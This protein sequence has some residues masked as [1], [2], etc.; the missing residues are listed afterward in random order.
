MKRDD[1]IFDDFGK[2][3]SLFDNLEVKKFSRRNDSKTSK[4]AV[5]TDKIQGELK[6]IWESIQ[7]FPGQDFTAK[8][9]A[10]HSDIDYII[11]SK[12]LS[13]LQRHGKISKSDNDE[14]KPLTRNGSAVWWVM[15]VTI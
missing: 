9:L 2:N 7:A 13:V 6:L 10:K 5:N 4:R 14:E 15:G 8:E 12:R 1:S 11:V 3:G